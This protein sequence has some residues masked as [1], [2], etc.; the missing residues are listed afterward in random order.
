[1]QDHPFSATDIRFS[2]ASDQSLLVKI[3]ENAGGSEHQQLVCLLKALEAA[4]IDGVVNLH[5]AYRS[6]LIV[7]NP[8]ALDHHVLEH[9]LCETISHLNAVPLPKP[10]TVEIQVQYGSEDGPD[11]NDVAMLHG[12]TPEQVIELHS[13]AT[14]V[15]R[16]FGFVPG[17]AY[18]DGLPPEIATPRLAV[19]RQRVPAGSVGIGGNQTGIYPF[20]TPG[21]WR[22][23]GRTSTEIFQADRGASLLA[24]GDLVRFVPV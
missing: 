3:K 2:Y 1:M 7:F 8:L 4:K 24:I 6:I 19:P 21:G 10:R 23:I 22:L 15:V 16:F 14:Y 9:K 5:P 18:L 11:L 12:L 17:F 13:T 20:A